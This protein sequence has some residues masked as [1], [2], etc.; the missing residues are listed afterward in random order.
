MLQG[1]AE[2]IHATLQQAIHQQKSSHGVHR[3]GHEWVTPGQRQPTQPHGQGQLQQQAQEEARHGN[4]GERNHTQDVVR[5]AVAPDSGRHAQRNTQQDSQ[6]HG[7]EH[8]LQ[9][10]RKKDR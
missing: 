9:R 10:S 6:A 4:G 7:G 3:I 5:P 8:Q 1:N 2:G